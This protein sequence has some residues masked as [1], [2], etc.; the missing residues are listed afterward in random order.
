[1][2][3]RREAGAL[4]YS[5]LAYFILFG[6]TLCGAVSFY[7]WVQIIGGADHPLPEP[8]TDPAQITRLNVLRHDRLGG[9]LHEYKHAA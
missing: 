9:T 7:F 8:I 3:T 4:F 2:L 6:F 1:M 5:P